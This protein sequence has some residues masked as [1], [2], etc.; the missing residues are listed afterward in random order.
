VRVGLDIGG[1]TGTFA[2]RMEERGVTVATTTLDHGAPL[3]A[4]VASGGLVQLHLGAV[5]RRL[6]FFDGTLDIV[7]S[8][9]AL[10]NWIP[11]EVVPVEAELYDIYRV[12]RAGGI[13]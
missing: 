13:F 9:H 7:H 1:G 8:M 2:A 12:L 5:A 4:F 10:G 6:P 3:G 11:G